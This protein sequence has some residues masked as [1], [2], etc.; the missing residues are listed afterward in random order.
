MMI[1]Y[2]LFMIYSTLCLN[3]CVF[4]KL[5]QRWNWK[6]SIFL[7]LHM[8]GFAALMS[9][10]RVQREI[11]KGNNSMSTGRAVLFGGKIYVDLYSR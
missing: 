11:L 9:R 7:P 10:A 8:Y 2:L 6:A 4:E 5:L 3:N 1:S